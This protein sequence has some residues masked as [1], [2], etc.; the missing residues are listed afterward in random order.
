MKG[1]YDVARHLVW[2]T[3]F[4]LSVG[5]PPTLC[6]AGSVWLRHRFTLG[7]WV[8]A[9]GVVV[10]VLAA[11]SCLRGSLQALDRQGRPA[12]KDGE[13]G[14]HPCKSIVMYCSRQAAWLWPWRSA[15][16]LCWRSMR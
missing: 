6:I 10:G 15:L 14:V 8:V 3:Q 7:G 9:V 4:G 13:R 1:L 16:P 12:K 5:V 11:V 2:L